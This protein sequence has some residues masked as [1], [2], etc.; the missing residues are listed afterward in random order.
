MGCTCGRYC[1]WQSGVLPP[2]VSKIHRKSSTRPT[3]QDTEPTSSHFSPGRACQD[4]LQKHFRT[5]S[6]ATARGTTMYSLPRIQTRPTA[7]ANDTWVLQ[8]GNDWLG[9]RC[10]FHE[11][12]PFD[13]CSKMKW[14]PRCICSKHSRTA[15]MRC[16]RVVMTFL[17]SD[18]SGIEL[19]SLRF[20]N[21]NTMGTVDLLSRPS[22]LRFTS[23]PAR[24]QVCSHPLYSSP[25]AW[26]VR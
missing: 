21:V 1:A 25:A 20:C 15:N 7:N 12:K 14:S 18:S 10:S 13:R 3:P 8:F 9:M 19:P 26:H 16:H 2:L 5:M 24:H 22:V 6:R 17:S 23:D 11:K 4:P